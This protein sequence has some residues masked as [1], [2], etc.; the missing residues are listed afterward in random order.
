MLLVCDRNSLKLHHA[1]DGQYVRDALP[2]RGG[3]EGGEDKA[4]WGA[5]TY[6]HV[7][8]ARIRYNLRL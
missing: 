6:D 1:M 7:I 3:R 4:C 2:D 8:V 5:G